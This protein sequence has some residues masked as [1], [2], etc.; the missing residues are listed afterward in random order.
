MVPWV[1]AA[2]A[3]ATA[4]TVAGLV[5]G[6]GA[7]LSGAPSRR[8]GGWVLVTCLAAAFV[9]VVGG[10]AL[11]WVA[12]DRGWVGPR[13]WFTLQVPDGYAGAAAIEWCP[14]RGQ[15]FGDVVVFDELGIAT[16]QAP[17][18]LATDRWE[19]RVV[20]PDGS[21]TTAMVGNR[22]PPTGDA[23]EVMAVVVDPMVPGY[24][25]GAPELY[26]AA[27]RRRGQPLSQSWNQL[28]VEV[29]VPDGYRGAALV[30]LCS[31]PGGLGSPLELGDQGTVVVAD[32]QFSLTP[33][34]PVEARERGGAVVEARVLRTVPPG[35]TGTCNQLE[36][37]VGA[38]EPQVS[39]VSPELVVREL[40][41]GGTYAAA[42]ARLT[43]P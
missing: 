14:D 11:G 38:D 35:P 13:Y 33:E 12:K 1:F 2:G 15:P 6:A 43:R 39:V 32:P 9:V 42:R 8:T 24:L 3:L 20:R 26:L 31:G 7:W 18:P 4:L 27:A 5:T 30:S 36:L 16:V 10:G 40:E 34:G 28:P 22:S 41:A 37:W 17:A 19:F 23:C 21:T 29:V 25:F